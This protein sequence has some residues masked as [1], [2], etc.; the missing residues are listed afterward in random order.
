MR[1]L[2]VH[3]LGGRPVGQHRQAH[4]HVQ[5]QARHARFFRGV[6]GLRGGASDDAVGPLCAVAEYRGLVTTGNRVGLDP[7]AVALAVDEQ[8]AAIGTAMDHGDLVAGEQR[9][10]L[11]A[12]DVGVTDAA[13]NAL[14]G[15]E[16]AQRGT[17]HHQPKLRRYLRGNRLQPEVGFDRAAQCRCDGLALVVVEGARGPAR[18]C[19]DAVAHRGC[20]QLRGQQSDVLD[21]AVLRPHP[22][23]L[24]VDLRAVE[25][26]RIG[27]VQAC[28]PVLRG[29]ER[30]VQADH[31][32][33]WCAG[34]G[35]RSGLRKGRR[36]QQ[37]QRQGQAARPMPVPFAGSQDHALH[38]LLECL[39][40]YLFLSAAKSRINY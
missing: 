29:Q 34:I 32:G 6:G 16:G 1:L 20:I 21:V 5:L 9:R 3:R 40:E 19:G 24:R 35:C 14:A 11:E 8:P 36:R 26:R 25:D 17:L 30:L 39:L 2:A 33:Q 27:V 7:R 12:V 4:A 10:F 18:Q 31:I 22:C 23:V 37:A 38:T 28:G 15:G 13:E